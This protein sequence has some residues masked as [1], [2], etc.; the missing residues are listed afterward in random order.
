MDMNRV[1]KRWSDS[2]VMLNFRNLDTAYVSWAMTGW[3]LV[4]HAVVAMAGG[5]ERPRVWAIYESLGLSRVDFL[6]GKFWQLFT[7]GFL[8]GGWWHV[9]SNAVFFLL[10]GSR[11]ECVAGRS[12]FIKA[13]I[14]GILGGGIG[15][16]LLAPGGAGAPLLVGLSGGCMSLLLL[17]CTLS[18]ESRMM[19]LPISA[20]SLGYGVM[21]SAL[22]L[23]LMNPEMQVPGFS[24]GG[25]FLSQNGMS[26]WFGMGHAC[27]FGGGLAGML[28]GKWMLR[29]R[30]T[31]KRLRHE[32]ARREA[33][34]RG[35]SQV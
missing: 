20:R 5:P 3:I 24:A 4:V 7:H 30:P 10:M 2:A 6:G 15:H 16:L 13:T 23:A 8:H 26:S 22:L 12:S 34:E 32:R 21:T 31:L 14:G 27:H 9:G 1:K 17:L 18:P 35:K 25:R 28:L 33:S 29:P 11:I 19:P